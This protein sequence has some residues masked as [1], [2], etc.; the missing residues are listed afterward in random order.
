MYL[1]VEMPESVNY[2][3]YLDGELVTARAADEEN[4]WV[5]IYVTNGNRLVYPYQIERRY[6]RVELRKK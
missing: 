1:S 2:Q 3:A 6:G 4:G 5:D